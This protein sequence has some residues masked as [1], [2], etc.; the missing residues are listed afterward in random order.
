[1]I[2]TLARPHYPDTAIDINGQ[3]ILMAQ[4]GEKK[5]EK[6]KYL[7]KFFLVKTPEDTIRLSRI[8]QNILSPESFGKLVKQI[9]SKIRCAPGR[10][11]VCLPDSIANV[12][13][14]Q[15]D[16]LPKGREKI[17]EMFRWKL[18]KATPFKIEE[19]KIDYS[20]YPTVDPSSGDK[21]NI[22]LVSIIRGRVIS[23]YEE[24][25]DLLGFQP[26][27]IT[28]S[29]FALFNLYKSVIKESMGDDSDFLLCN[30]QDAFFSFLIFRGSSP[31]FYRCKS[32]PLDSPSLEHELYSMI[33]RELA[34]TL[35]F[36]KTRLNGKGLEK[37]FLRAIGRDGDVL[38]D[39]LRASGRGEVEWIE[40]SRLLRI[41]GA[42]SN[43]PILLQQASSVLGLA[44]RRFE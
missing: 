28:L 18:K 10:I 1:M 6:E 35:E 14:M 16:A 20:I 27:L 3:Y 41:D 33:E 13:I 23:Q 19:G 5:D 38:F 44:M 8:N 29:S 25:F 30:C 40:P 22:V 12:S 36:Y 17:L 43:R 37:I 34:P 42:L 31:I 7:K 32:I 39:I 26:G 11:S 2:K 9:S 15:V 24:L 4:V 21:K